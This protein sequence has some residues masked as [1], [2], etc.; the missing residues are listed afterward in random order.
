MT[1]LEHAFIKR[2]S[3]IAAGI[4]YNLEKEEIALYCTRFR[5]TGFDK[6]LLALSDLEL[7]NDT[8]MLP[9]PIEM[10]RIASAYDKM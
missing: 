9:S 5:K 7:D 2:L 1:N 6:A 4:G 10:E 3:S 8:R